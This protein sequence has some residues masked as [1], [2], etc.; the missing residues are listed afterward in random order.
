MGFPI[1]LPRTERGVMRFSLGLKGL[2]LFLISTPSSNRTI[3]KKTWTE[4]HQGLLQYHPT[5]E[6]PREADPDS[7]VEQ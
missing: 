7:T 2:R 3:F 4:G 1:A 5:P 6:N